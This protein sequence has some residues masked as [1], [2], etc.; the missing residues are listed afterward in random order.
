MRPRLSVRARK[1]LAFVV[2]SQRKMVQTPFVIR[3]V[4]VQSA[5]QV[6]S[7]SVIPNYDSEIYSKFQI[8]Q[9]ISQAQ[10]MTRSIPQVIKNRRLMRG[11]HNHEENEAGDSVPPSPQSPRFWTTSTRL[12]FLQ[13]DETRVSPVLG[14]PMATAM[15]I[16]KTPKSHRC[17]A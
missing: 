12:N 2:S 16:A 14:I 3:I 6:T 8:P 7:Y 10:T 5:L 13:I 11:I 9:S 17:L 15:K 1:T 4:L